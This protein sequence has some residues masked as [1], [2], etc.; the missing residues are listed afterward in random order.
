M[1]LVVFWDLS[2]GRL[3]NDMSMYEVL[4][5]RFCCYLALSVPIFGGSIGDL[6][7]YLILRRAIYSFCENSV[8]YLSL[9]CVE[10][11]FLRLRVIFCWGNH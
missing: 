11:S 1:I 4:L 8:S 6:F 5:C 7:R 10:M 9:L 3:V 2:F